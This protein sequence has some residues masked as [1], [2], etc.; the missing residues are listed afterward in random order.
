[1]ARLD[2]RFKRGHAIRPEYKAGDKVRFR[3]GAEEKVGIFLE[4]LPK[5]DEDGN[6]RAQVADLPRPRRTSPAYDLYEQDILGLAE[7]SNPPRKFKIGDL[8]NV[9]AYV[10]G[11]L[12][13]LVGTV[14]EYVE[15][16]ERKQGWFVWVKVENG[17]GNWRLAESELT[18][19]EPQP[20]PR[21]KVGDKV[22]FLSEKEVMGRGLPRRPRSFNI[23]CD[24][25]S[26]I[27]GYD[28]EYDCF[29]VVVGGVVRLEKHFKEYYLEESAEKAVEKE[30]PRPRIKVGDRVTCM[31]YGKKRTGVVEFIRDPASRGD[32]D[33]M[34][35]ARC[36]KNP[37]RTYIKLERAFTVVQEAAS[38]S[39]STS[40]VVEPPKRFW[41]G[42]SVACGTQ[43]FRVQSYTSYFPLRDCWYM[44]VVDSSGNK[45][46]ALEE[47]F[48]SK[49]RSPLA[50]R[51][52]AEAVRESPRFSSGEYLTFLS[53]NEAY[54][55]RG[56]TSRLGS[57]NYHFGGSEQCGVAAEIISYDGYVAQANCWK[58]RVKLLKPTKQDVFDN[59]YFMLESEFEEY[60]TKSAGRSSCKKPNKTNQN[61]GQK[62]NVFGIPVAVIRREKRKS[63]PQVGKETRATAARGYRR[64]R[65]CAG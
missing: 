24:T 40:A 15:S 50:G 32:D 17:R 7:E 31:E 37:K 4:Y 36:V 21:L 43:S 41:I 8:V 42:E 38:A 2:K 19:C 51:P 3:F 62:T 1:M 34:V 47:D 46:D 64:D 12:E 28:E 61:N 35:V 52:A 44:T 20:Q 26:F 27:K 30:E 58:I 11:K 56:D 45:F 65:G 60:Y 22:T 39:T 54:K 10:S 14:V 6:R 25:I 5:T 48:T 63:Q 16:P 23:P 18:L 57:G 49:Y 55:R 53:R 9:K 29:N 13:T 59:E 33:R